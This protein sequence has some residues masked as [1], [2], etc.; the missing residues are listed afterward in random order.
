MPSVCVP[1]RANE[2]SALGQLKGEIASSMVG[3]LN[4][5]GNKGQRLRVQEAKRYGNEIHVTNAA[6]S[7]ISFPFK[8][9]D[10]IQ[11]ITCTRRQTQQ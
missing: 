6:V 4:K 9:T 3:D 8:L 2:Q 5:W 7:T 11:I 10:F 1:E